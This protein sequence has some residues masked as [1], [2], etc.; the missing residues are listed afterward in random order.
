MS[1]SLKNFDLITV[2]QTIVNSSQTGELSISADD[3]SLISAFFFEAGQPRGAQFQHLTGEE[4]FWQ[5][6]LADDLAR[7][8]FVQVRR[9]RRRAKR[10]RAARSR[11]APAT[12]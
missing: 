2:Y 10:S 7:H 3:G 1:G 9:G 4:A 12:C 6:F 5:L 8:V 11:A